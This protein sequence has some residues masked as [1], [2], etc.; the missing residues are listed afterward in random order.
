MLALVWLVWIVFYGY[1]LWSVIFEVATGRQKK[2]EAA[3]QPF[4]SSAAQRVLLG[5]AIV[6]EIEPSLGFLGTLLVP[7]AL[8][9]QALGM[10]VAFTGVGLAVWARSHLGGN[11]SGDVTIKKGHTLTRTGP[12]GLVRHPIYLGILLMVVGCATAL[13]TVGAGIAVVAGLLFVGLRVSTE[14]KLMR[15]K[16]GKEWELYKK[17]VRY[18]IVPGV[19]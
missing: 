5:I 4:S 19:L 7:H 11:W 12:Y 10:L 9:L 3:G 14:E 18:V 16:F 6:L 17:E 2:R 1:W 15:G 8:L 13:G